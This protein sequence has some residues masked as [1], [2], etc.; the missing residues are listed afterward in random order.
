MQTK[1]AWRIRLD[2]G[3][4]CKIICGGYVGY[5]EALKEA[6]MRFGARVVDVE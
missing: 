3:R 2:C 6:R 5:D 1:P 4:C